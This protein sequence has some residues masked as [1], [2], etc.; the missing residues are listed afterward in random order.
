MASIEK[1]TRN[2]Q[3]RWYMRYRD[4]AGAQ[5]AEDVRPQGRRRA[6]PDDG[7]VSQ[8][9]RLL[10]RPCGFPAHGRDLGAALARLARLHLKPS[11]RERYAGIL[12]KHID[13]RWGTTKRRTSHTAPFRPW[14]SEV[15]GVEIGSATPQEMHRVLSLVLADGGEGRPAGAQPSRGRFCSPRQRRSAHACLTSRCTSSAEACGSH[16]LVVLLL[17]YTG[18]R[19]GEMAALR[20]GRLDRCAG[21]RRSPNR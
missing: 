9:D 21:E 15:G 3:V 11:T 4:P 6:I 5:R 14:V 1:R 7:R 12:R 17:A 18:V 2:G 20:V 8:A 10:Y 19:F 13:P 16:R